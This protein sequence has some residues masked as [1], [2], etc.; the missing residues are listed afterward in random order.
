VSAC[1]G[2]RQFHFHLTGFISLSSF[3]SVCVLLN[4]KKKKKTE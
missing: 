3:T 4:E 2:V 1:V